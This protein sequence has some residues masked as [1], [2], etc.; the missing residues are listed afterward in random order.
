M[1]AGKI[2]DCEPMSR[3]CKKC[4]LK[5]KLK[6][7]NPN[8]FET[9]KS[10]HLCKLNYHGSA[11]GMKVIGAQ[12]MFSHLISQ[13]KLRYVNYYGDGSCKSYSCV[14]DTYPGIMV[15][16]LEGVGHVQKRFGR[17]LRIYMILVHVHINNC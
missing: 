9:W 7:S 15:C 6:E 10:S 3:S 11:P 12:I 5:L 1:E 14:K 2:F 13:N 4:N 17:S 8:A 16:K